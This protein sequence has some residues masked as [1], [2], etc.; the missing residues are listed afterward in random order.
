MQRIT[1][2]VHAEYQNDANNAL[3]PAVGQVTT[4]KHTQWAL[5]ADAIT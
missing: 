4:E 5:I 2:S 1:L 3:R